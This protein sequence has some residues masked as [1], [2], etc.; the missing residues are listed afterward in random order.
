MKDYNGKICNCARINKQPKSMALECAPSTTPLPVTS[1][2]SRPSPRHTS[3]SAAPST[4]HRPH[5]HSKAQL[6]QKGPHAPTGPPPG[7]VSA[8]AAGPPPARRWAGGGEACSGGAAGPSAPRAPPSAAS[9]SSP[10]GLSPI[11][12]APSSGAPL[13]A[14]CLRSWLSDPSPVLP[15][16]ASA[17]P[18]PTLPT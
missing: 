15:P 11:H 2:P 14:C 7:P 13:G 12:V 16:P 6:Q 1:R 3:S 5:W 17:H 18:A 9:S 10:R 8:P 4:A